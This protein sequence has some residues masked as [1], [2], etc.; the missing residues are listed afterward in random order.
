MSEPLTRTF[1]TAALAALSSGVGLG[2]HHRHLPESHKAA[3]F[4]LGRVV[5]VDE[6]TNWHF[7]HAI[8]VALQQQHP[9]LPVGLDLHV[10]PDTLQA[11]ISALEDRLGKTLCIH[12]I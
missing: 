4:L 11:T 6:F 10:K 8:Q 12:P 7:W 1:S 9:G 5:T 2:P 3:E